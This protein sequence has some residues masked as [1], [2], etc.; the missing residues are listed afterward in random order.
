MLPVGSPENYTKAMN[1][2]MEEKELVRIPVSNTQTVRH[3]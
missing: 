2:C 3:T 1:E